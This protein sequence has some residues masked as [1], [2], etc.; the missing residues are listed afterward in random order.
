MS[1]QSPKTPEQAKSHELKE[2]EAKSKER[3]QETIEKGKEAK[4][5]AKDSLES[6]RSSIEHEADTAQHVKQEQVASEKRDEGP[7]SVLIDRNLKNKAYKKEL[8]RVQSHLP[9]AQRSFSKFIHAPS[10]EAVSEVGGKTVARPSG[11]LGGGIVALLGSG[12]LVWTSRHYGFQYNFFVFIA[13]LIAG[14]FVGL[15]LEALL[16][17]VIKPKA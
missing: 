6:I 11:L 17:M 7:S 12:L 1:E 13:L 4:N 16:R 5:D 9:K 14:F 15:I 2:A 10:I 3:L 8:H